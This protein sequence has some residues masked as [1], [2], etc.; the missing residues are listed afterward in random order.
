MRI[1]QTIGPNLAKS[2]GGV[3][4]RNG[5]LDTMTEKSQTSNTYCSVAF[6]HIYSSSEGQYKLCCHSHSDISQYSPNETLPFEYFFSDEMENIRDKMLSGKKISGC[7]VCYDIEKSGYASPRIRK[8]NKYKNLTTIGEIQLKLRIFGNYCNLACY[9]CFP[10]NSSTRAKELKEIGIYDEISRGSNY[11]VSIN[12]N[13]WKRVKQNVLDNIHLIESLHLTGG[14]PLQ[15]PRQYEFLDEIPDECAK[16]ITLTY[17]T[18]LTQLGHKGKHIFDYALKFKKIHFSV[19]SDHFGKKLEWIRYPI[20]YKQFEDNIREVQNYR[21]NMRIDAIN[22]SVSILNVEDLY[23]IEEYYR[24]NFGLE[25]KFNI[26]VEKPYY[27]NIKNHPL[28]D[29]LYDKYKDDPKMSLVCKNLLQ[30]T[31]AR[32]WNKGIDY[33]HTLNNHRKMNFSELWPDYKNVDMIH[34]INI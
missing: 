18:N 3:G 32:Q 10:F 33:I 29:Q 16:K 28:K 30:A 9:M 7:E 11:G 23:E 4:K 15:L 22:L 5:H 8:Y 27:L 20:D 6:Y 13:N 1:Q 19:S 2:V 26:V 21:G 31:D 14:E 24:S 17:D 34:V 25:T 12:Y